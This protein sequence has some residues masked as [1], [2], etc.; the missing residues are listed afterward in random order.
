MLYR[1]IRSIKNEWTE[2]IHLQGFCMLCVCGVGIFVYKY[3]FI[4]IK[5]KTRYMFVKGCCFSFSC[6]HS[7][8][9]FVVVVGGSHTVGSQSDSIIYI[10]EKRGGRGEGRDGRWDANVA[11]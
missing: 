1:E 10:S 4:V 3:Q 9:F 6:K 2:I 11:G 7:Q 5:L 8:Q